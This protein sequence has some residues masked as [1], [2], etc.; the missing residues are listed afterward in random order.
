MA[1]LEDS[2]VSM[3]LQFNERFLSLRELKRQIVYAVRRDNMRIRDIDAEVGI[4]LYCTVYSIVSA[5]A[6]F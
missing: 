2:M 1:L 4:S 5:Y 6:S 3:R